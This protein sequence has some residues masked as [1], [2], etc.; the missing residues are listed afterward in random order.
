MGHRPLHL[1]E[2]EITS[3]VSALLSDKAAVADGDLF[4]ARFASLGQRSQQSESSSHRQSSYRRFI[5]GSF[6]GDTDAW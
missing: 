3:Q 4:V 6:H 1:G 2:G 5:L